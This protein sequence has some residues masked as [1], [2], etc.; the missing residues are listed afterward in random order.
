MSKVLI[1]T[2]LAV[3]LGFFLFFRFFWPS[4]DKGVSGV[5]VT[6]GE[7]QY[8]VD[9][10]NT[11][12]LQTQGLS[13]RASLAEGTG[14]LFVFSQPS[15]QAFWMKGMLFPIDIIWIV[16]S[17]VIGFVEN[18]QPDHTILPEVFSSPKPVTLVLEVPAGT[19][20]NDTI[21]VGDKVDVL[22]YTRN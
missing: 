4:G 8:T 13:G 10:A 3:A 7:H 11:P 19:V 20:K 22:G 9:V 5:T 15:T 21:S 2:I 18:A 1:I 6:I 12:E 17:H 14:M 16:D